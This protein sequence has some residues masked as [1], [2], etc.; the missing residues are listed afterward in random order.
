MSTLLFR[1]DWMPIRYPTNVT[2]LNAILS[3]Y[4]NQRK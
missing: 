3:I 4:I 2:A 1:L